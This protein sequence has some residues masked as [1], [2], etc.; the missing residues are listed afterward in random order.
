TRDSFNGMHL[1]VLRGAV[2]RKLDQ[3]LS[4][5]QLETH[6]FILC[7]LKGHPSEMMA[8]ALPATDTGV[9][10]LCLQFHGKLSF[11]DGHVSQPET[12]FSFATGTDGYPLTLAAEKQW[13]LLLGVSGPSHQLLL[14][15]L[16]PLRELHDEPQNGLAAYPITFADR[17]QLDAFS[18]LAFG[19]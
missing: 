15:E 1:A 3:H 12:F 13:A 8:F 2:R 6:D 7:E 19:P 17:R 4:L 16:A 11:R 9:L 14:A 18:K 5:I 10:W